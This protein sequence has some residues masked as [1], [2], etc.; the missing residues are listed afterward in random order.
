MIS[1]EIIGYVTTG[2][3]SFIKNKGYGVGSA[4]KYKNLFEENSIFLV[5]K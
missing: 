1:R 4:F 2:G 5:R 3:F